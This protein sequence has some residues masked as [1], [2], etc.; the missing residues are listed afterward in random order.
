[1]AKK[2]MEWMTNHWQ[3]EIIKIVLSE[4]IMQWIERVLSFVYLKEY[5]YVIHNSSLS[6]VNK[7]ITDIYRYLVN[8]FNC[9]RKL[10]QKVSHLLHI[11]EAALAQA[12]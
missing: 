11:F 6:Y 10:F 1:M 5:I 3:V 9:P 8:L 4:I 2:V 12:S 7:T